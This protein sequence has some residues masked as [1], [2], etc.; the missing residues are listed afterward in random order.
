MLT[1]IVLCLVLTW[2]GYSEA[3]ELSSG[4][5][6]R[7][8]QATFEVVQ[9]KPPEEGVTYERPLPL[10]LLPYQERTDHYRS[11]GTAFALGPNRYATAGHVITVGNGSQAGPPALR[12]ASGKVYEIADVLG[13]AER[14]DFVV[15][16]LR[17]PPA[18]VQAL[19]TGPRPA[20][21]DPV[22]SVGNALGAGVVIRDGVFTSET[23]E[24]QDGQWKWLRF[25]AAASP[26]NSGGPLVD[27]DGRVVG[28]ILRRSPQENL[29]YALP[30]SELLNAKPGE[31][32]IVGHATLRF[33]ALAD[34][35]QT[36]HQNE[37]FALPLP[38]AEF[39]RTTHRIT[40][41]SIERGYTQ[42][43]TDNAAKL[44]PNGP[45]SE[46]LLRVVERQLFP[47]LMREGG[48]GE[49][50]M[51]T[52]NPGSTQLDKN[53]FVQRGGLFFRLHAPDDVSI[54][55]LTS[56]SKGFMDLMLKAMPERRSVG[57]D[58]V[59]ITSLG[60]AADDS[61]HTDAYGRVWQVRTW[62]IPFED[63]R[64]TVVS[65]ATPDG[66]VGLMLRAPSG[67]SDVLLE[68]QERMLDYVFVTMQGTL[69]QWQAYLSE[70]RSLLPASFAS[71]TIQIDP[72]RR[73]HVHSSHY[74]FDVSPPLVKLSNSSILRLNFSYFREGEHVVWGLGGV[75]VGEGMQEHN[76]VNFK[77][78]SAPAST[79]PDSV[80]AEWRKT[81]N[82]E[83]PFNST[84]HAVN[85]EANIATSVAGS[86]QLYYTLGVDADAGQQQGPMSEKLALLVK[87]FKA[88]EQTVGASP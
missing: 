59:R 34:A 36:I 87:A 29:N 57:S 3:A 4:V 28:V 66:L 44:F 40:A 53:G 47:T 35:T 81:V 20:L 5:Q 27:R 76:W 17:N 1:W 30:I 7:I 64:L 19:A 88:T 77:R 68:E 52:S 31:G 10:D 8:R 79:L 51:G 18:A 83:Y 75:A 45:G 39:Y 62:P 50:G 37:H 32:R 13:Y 78:W 85:G 80:Q 82:H 12:D 2:A 56:D 25:T 33:F 60:K 16:S 70:E 54:A 48:S 24:E 63:V 38:L 72:E 58:S 61:R 69:A 73:V 6:K 84:V 49:W 71:L 23:P 86:P 22:Y 14:E 15:F 65:L 43:V 55:S 46:R 74:D 11:I 21:N 41:A 26:G 42:M 67:L 9:P